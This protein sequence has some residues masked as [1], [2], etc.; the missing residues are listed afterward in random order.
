MNSLS[1]SLSKNANAAFFGLVVALG[2][3]LAT[4]G[5][6]F[7][8]SDSFSLTLT[9]PLFQL[10]IGPG[11]FW[12]S[13]LKAV[14]TN[15]YEI[16]LYATVMNFSANGDE[17]QGKFTPIVGE[18][19]E[20]KSQT[21][22]GWIEVAKEPVVVAP[23]QSVDIPFSV[24]IPEDASPGGHYAAILVGTQPLR[25]EQGGPVIRVSSFISSLFFVRIKGEVFENASIREFIVGSSWR[26]DA[27][28]PMSLRV[29]NTGTVHILPAGDVVVYDMWGIERGRV[30]VNQNNNFGNVLP[31]SVRKFELEWA[32]EVSW[33]NTGLYSAVVTLGFGDEEKQSISSE[34]HFWVVPITP[35]AILGG[36]ILVLIL[37]LRWMIRRSIRRTLGRYHFAPKEDDTS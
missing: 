2:V 15:D 1:T 17:G 9:P 30:P 3:L 8:Q 22:A 4:P 23:G 28:I 5:I 34:T 12:A 21:L 27:R 14:N 10:S 25:D 26:S 20:E 7:A 35:L 16:T 13:S 6:L 18:S 37:L 33:W 24:R 32:G 29:E 36:G 31:H 11:E 19:S